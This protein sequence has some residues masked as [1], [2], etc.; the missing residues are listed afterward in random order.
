[1]PE[2]LRHQQ[3][4]CIYDCVYVGEARVSSGQ[5][6]WFVLLAGRLSCFTSPMQPAATFNLMQ[7]WFW[8]Q[9]WQVDL[10]DQDVAASNHAQDEV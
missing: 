3:W 5:Q 6:W 10:F 4:L 1:M 8:L 2:L 9:G 7:W